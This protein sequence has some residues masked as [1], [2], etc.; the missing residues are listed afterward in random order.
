MHPNRAQ[1]LFGEPLAKDLDAELAGVDE[2]FHLSFY[3]F[4]NF[5]FVIAGSI[6][7]LALRTGS[8]TKLFEYELNGK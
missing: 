5:S 2:I 8:W 1:F 6:N 7:C 3:I 4:H